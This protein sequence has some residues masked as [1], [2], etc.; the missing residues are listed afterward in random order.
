MMGG[1]VSESKRWFWFIGM[2]LEIARDSAHGWPV[3]GSLRVGVL[4]G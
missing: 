4:D 1:L 2:P 3:D